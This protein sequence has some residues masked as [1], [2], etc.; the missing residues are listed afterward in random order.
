VVFDNVCGKCH[1][2]GD[3][4]VNFGPPLTEIGSKY[5]KESLYEHTL[6]PAAAVSFGYEGATVKIKGGDEVVG[7][8]VS[9]TE[10][11]LAVKTATGVAT[12]YKKADVISRRP[13]KG[14]LMPDGLQ[15]TMSPDDLADLVEYMASLKKPGAPAP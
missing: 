7:I 3:K 13:L 12:A 5:G 6:Y 10:D 2:V 9:E 11:E 14:S 1:Q 4:G 15:Q 8:V